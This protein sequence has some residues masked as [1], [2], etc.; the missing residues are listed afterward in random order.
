MLRL[1]LIPVSKRGHGKFVEYLG[2]V[3]VGKYT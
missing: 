1:K 3:N 2:D